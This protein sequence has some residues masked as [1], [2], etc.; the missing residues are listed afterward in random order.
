M[1]DPNTTLAYALGHI[2][3]AYIAEAELPELTTAAS[4]PCHPHRGKDT[5]RFW[6]S[7]WFA[8]AISA[9]VAIGTLAGIVWAGQK[10]PVHPV[11]PPV[12]TN[13]PPPAVTE[14]ESAEDE[15]DEPI[16]PY[17]EGL[18]YR[19][20]S[21]TL[22]QVVG[23]G[24]ATDATVIHIP[25]KDEQG[26]DIQGIGKDAFAGNTN[27]TEVVFS[28]ASSLGIFTVQ[29]S[30]FENCTSLQRVRICSKTIQVA[31]FPACF[32][33][34][35]NL[36]EIDCPSENDGIYFTASTMEGT[37]WL[38]SQTEDFVIFH[39]T[40]LKYQGK[41][42][43]VVLPDHIRY[44]AGGAFEGCHT[45]TSVTASENSLLKEL[46]SRVFAGADSLKT[47]H[48]PN[49]EMLPGSAFEDCPALETVY[50]PLSIKHLLPDLPDNSAVFL[51]AGTRKEWEKIAFYND[52]CK[53]E[54][55]GRV[56]FQ[57]K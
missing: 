48:L 44:V 27:I 21:P 11:V 57:N 18:E 13:V 5:P 31:L 7:N 36:S 25:P 35:S 14:N 51:Y 30:A 47:V 23:I 55:E 6:E 29:D 56:I 37:R 26:R 34:C 15:T 4:C 32:R 22:V 43:D 24:T 42:A 49:L 53:V 33:G 40:L 16:P 28:D 54:W 9:V 17:T 19:E 20:I 2:D 45:V 10:N 50:L 38:E 1:K 41:T 12:G 39:G 46:S 8:A 3:A 52:D